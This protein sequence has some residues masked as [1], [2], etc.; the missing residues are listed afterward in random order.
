MRDVLDVIAGKR[1]AG[2]N[3]KKEKQ[4]AGHSKPLEKNLEKTHSKGHTAQRHTGITGKKNS[5]L[6]ANLVWKHSKFGWERWVSASTSAS[7]VGLNLDRENS[8][9]R[10]RDM[11]G[12]KGHGRCQ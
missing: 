10:I 4:M 6:S 8:E 11:I 5:G 7:T 1:A 3:L 12:P 9:G 2:G